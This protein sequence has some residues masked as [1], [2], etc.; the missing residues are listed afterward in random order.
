MFG[1]LGFGLEAEEDFVAA[2]GAGGP[3]GIVVGDEG[4]VFGG[5]V[6]GFGPGLQGSELL[7]FDFWI[8]AAAEA[9][10]DDFDGGKLVEGDVTLGFGCAF[11]SDG[12]GHDEAHGGFGAG[13]LHDY[14]SGHGDLLTGFVTAVDEAEEFHE[15][16][17][18]F[19]GFRIGSR[20]GDFGEV[21]GVVESDLE[22]V[23]G[24][25][26]GVGGGLGGGA[27]AGDE[28]ASG[29]K[30]DEE[31]KDPEHAFHAKGTVWIGGRMRWGVL[32]DDDGVRSG[33]VRLRP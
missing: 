9:D 3:G 24:F 13:A 25:E 14:G 5:E 33:G 11:G 10:D 7:F 28:E 32:T 21:Q 31:G 6:F 19:L 1:L 23:V 15:G 20:E 18:H 4:C 17:I 22:L 16:T 27:R 2:E 26:D 29:E 30:E 8:A 12:F